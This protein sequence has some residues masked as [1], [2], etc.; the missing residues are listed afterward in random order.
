MS[1]LLQATELTVARHGFHAA[2]T[3]R[4]AEAA[5]VSIGTLYHYFPTKEALVEAV[6]HRMWASELEALQAH[7]GLLATAPLDEAVRAIVSAL[8]AVVGARR[9][10][11]R[12]WYAEAPHLGELRVGLDM[13]DVAVGV[14]RAALEKRRAEVRPADV[15]FA[16]DL[17]IKTALAVVRTAARDYPEQIASGALAAELGEM[18]AGYLVK[19][20]PA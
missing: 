16:T 13:S 18:L 19:R 14:V 7:V 11:Y 4:I 2:T 5:G 8:V 20:T 10:L 1:V 6:V 17:V 12:R 15:G 9:E 3:N